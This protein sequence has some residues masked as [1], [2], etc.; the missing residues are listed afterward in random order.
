MKRKKGLNTPPASRRRM[1]IKA[2]ASMRDEPGLVVNVRAAKDQLSA[3]LEQAAQGHEVI[4]TS[5]GRPKARLTAVQRQR[6]PFRV[7]WRLLRTKVKKGPLA[8]DLVR[9]ERDERD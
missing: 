9:Q 2:P 7:N 5:D 3:L 8:E 6:P 1:K 4:I